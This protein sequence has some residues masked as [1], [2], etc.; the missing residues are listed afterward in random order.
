M[1]P[2]YFQN[3]ES[4]YPPVFAQIQ[5]SAET[6]NRKT[7]AY[8]LAEFPS[9][10]E[11]FI[12]KEALFINE[13]IPLYIIALKKGNSLRN[14][15]V[16]SIFGDKLIYIPQW[17]S[18]KILL[19]AVLNVGV[20]YREI[21]FAG[22]K[23]SLRQ[24]KVLLIASFVSEKI[25]NLPI[26]HIHAHFANYPTD[27]AMMISR[28]SS[29]PFSFTAHANDIYVN[30]VA[31]PEKIRKATFVTTCTEYNKNRLDVMT[32]PAASGKIHLVYHGVDTNYWKFH[33]LKPVGNP[34]CILTIGRLVEKKGMI[35]LL[36][37]VSILLKK[38]V[39]VQ[40]HIVGK[41]IEEQ[42]LKCF[43]RKFGLEQSVVFMG[44]QS[45][46]QIKDLYVHSDIFVLPSVVA[47]D[48][49]MDGIPNVILEAMSV[50]MPV[51]STPVSGIP[52]V[53]QNGFNGLLVPERDSKQLANAVFILIS[54]MQLRS[55]LVENA[56]KTILEKFDSNQCNQLLTNLFKDTILESVP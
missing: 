23:N 39:A 18:W 12:L 55:A 41:G 56:Y 9:Q 40:L 22:F 42:Q 10:T 30:P 14:N 38:G 20:L 32:T 25:T 8:I 47:P 54:D 4:F 27:V 28:L 1:G 11:T 35:Y 52:E 26:Q 53:I 34:V 15:R 29:L 33:Q 5:I 7:I 16:Y 46:I 48:G 51:I 50:G 24:M 6:M 37:T 19:H 13:S 43:C 44:W 3:I 49:D 2:C 45:P 17:R 36:E 21:T 31:L